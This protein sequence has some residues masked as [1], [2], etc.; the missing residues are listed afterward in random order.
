MDL[1]QYL[2]GCLNFDV[3]EYFKRYIAT[4]PTVRMYTRL[5]SYHA[6]N[7]VSVNHYAYC[8][9]QRLCSFRLQQDYP[10]PPRP[11]RVSAT[12]ADVAGGSELG[13]GASSGT[14]D[15]AASW[16]Q[17]DAG[18]SDNIATSSP[19]VLH[20]FSCFVRSRLPMQCGSFNP[21]PQPPLS[22]PVLSCP[23]FSCPLLS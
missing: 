22:C 9:L 21:I 5:L 16:A 13:R 7:D 18:K 14:G 4:N 15:G 11:P 2:A 12:A 23:H 8:Y 20:V 19:A 17:R 10:A 3:N 6:S 1:E